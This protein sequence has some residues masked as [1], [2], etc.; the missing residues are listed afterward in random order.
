MSAPERRR[1]RWSRL[2]LLAAA[3]L[4]ALGCFEVLLHIF[5]VG[6]YGV[7]EDKERFTAA[8]LERD[9]RGWLRLRPGIT[10]TYLGRE[11]RISEQRLRN[12]TV[13]VPKPA[14]VYR[15]LVVGDS[16]PFGWGVGEDEPFPRLLEKELQKTARADGRTYEVVNGGSPGWGLAEEYFWLEAIGVT[17]APDFVLHSIINNDIEA[18]PKAPL[19]F[20]GDTLRR[21][22]TLRLIEA[23]AGRITGTS[24]DEPGTALAPEHVVLAIGK[25]RELCAGK[26]AGYAVIDAFE[27]VQEEGQPERRFP[28]EAVRYMATVG[29]P[30]LDLA[31]TREWVHAHQVARGDYHPGAA[32]HAEIAAKLLPMVRSLVE[33]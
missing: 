8:I 6:G 10:A 32:G 20:L 19:L 2:A 31:L 21:V 29:V 33:K 24:G 30:L 7:L 9:E 12:R 13:V 14:G 23:I 11:V 16:V 15:I 3:T 27:R 25:F 28:P 1:R 18:H 17:F 26:G 5:D 4:F 22:R